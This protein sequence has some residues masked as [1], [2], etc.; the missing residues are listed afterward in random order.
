MN[1]KLDTTK[2]KTLLTFSTKSTHK[3]LLILILRHH[4]HNS[5]RKTPNSPA[6]LTKGGAFHKAPLGC[7]HSFETRPG[8]RPGQV[9]GLRVRWVDPVQPKKKTYKKK[10]IT[11]YN[12]TLT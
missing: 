3:H 11:S 7:S 4:F 10:H 2:H 5:P 9:I 1:Y 8:H 6:T 12:A